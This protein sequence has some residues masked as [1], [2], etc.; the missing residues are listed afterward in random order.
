MIAG[1]ARPIVEVRAGA[2]LYG[3]ATPASDFDA[4]SVFLPAAR[5]ILLQ[6][7]QATIVESRER[8]PGE[9][10]APGDV[11]VES[12]SLHRFLTL[13]AAGQPLAIEILFTPDVFMLS[14]PDKLWREVQAIGPSLITR[15]AGIFARYCRKQ[16]EQYGVKGERAAAARMALVALMAAE[17]V[18]GTQARLEE[19]A[20]ELETLAIASPHIALVDVEVQENRTVRHLE[21]CGRK[22]PFTA[23]IRAAREMTERLVA[24]YGERALEAERQ[25]GVDWKALS[26]AVRVGREAVELFT[27]GRLHFPLASAPRLLDIKLGRV[28]YIEV[29]R[30]IE[31]LLGEVEHSAAAS[32]LPDEPDLV[33]AEALVIRAYRDQVVESMR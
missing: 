21:V 25:S 20:V 33:A 13:L 22:A 18:R 10:N 14:P 2:H 32:T 17:A 15:R 9:R 8:A 5:D 29:A 31:A 27:T 1:S 6:Q 4:K 16:A 28:P 12:H 19:I 23:M 3:T 30:E 24:G 26:H 11:D 7:V